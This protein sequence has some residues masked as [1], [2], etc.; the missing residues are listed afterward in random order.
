MHNLQRASAHSALHYFNI[1]QRY[2]KQ[3]GKTPLDIAHEK[4]EETALETKQVTVSLATA[5]VS[6]AIDSAVALTKPIRNVFF[7]QPLLPA[8]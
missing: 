1:R 4:I 5:V 7:P 3:P 6:T 2:R 8:A